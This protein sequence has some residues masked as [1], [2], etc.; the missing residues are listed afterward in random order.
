[1]STDRSNPA[2]DASRPHQTPV[3]V[4]RRGSHVASSSDSGSDSGSGQG[5]WPSQA[6]ESEW[7]EKPQWSGGEESGQAEAVPWRAEESSWPQAA[8]APWQPDNGNAEQPSWQQSEQAW[9]QQEEQ[10][11]PQQEQPAWNASAQPNWGAGEQQQGQQNEGD[12]QQQPNEQ[13]PGWTQQGPGSGQQHAVSAEHSHQAPYAP[14]AE[15]ATVRAASGPPGLNDE[16]LLTHRRQSSSRG[17]RRAVSTITLGAVKPGLS[18][19]EVTEAEQ[20]RSIRTP[21][22]GCHRIGV[23][24]LKGGIGKT[25]TAA[26]LGLALA[27]TRGDGVVAVDANPDAGT[28]SD[29]LVGAPPDAYSGAEWVGAHVRATDDTW[30]AP[31]SVRDLLAAVSADEIGSATD[32]MRYVS[33]AGRLH[34][35]ASEQD[36]ETSE[37]FNANEYRTTAEVISAFYSVMITD[38]G[39]GLL[40]SAMAGM[41]SMAD[42]L[43]IIAAPSVDGASRAA[44]TLDWLDAHHYGHLVARAVVAVSHTRPRAQNVDMKVLDA[45]FRARCRALVHVPY[46]P[47]L[48]A[49]S[50]IRWNEMAAATRSSFL[51]LAATVADDFREGW[52]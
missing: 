47:H 32:V 46:D 18:A 34:V 39:T 51:E 27:T 5:G 37:A 50:V 4:P 10:A 8:E 35:L 17:W 24:S 28:L 33:I 23:V 43:V 30:I 1:M 31:R 7:D 13:Q 11:W 49:G 21:I 9:P 38:T 41:L 25:T 22:R 40:H 2:D 14:P 45:H 3:A 48:V 29:R 26:G 19:A 16:S 15:H 6:G 42:S 20:L 12:W 36:P 44:K 52:N